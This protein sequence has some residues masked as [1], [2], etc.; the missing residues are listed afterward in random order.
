MIASKRLA[1]SALAVL[2]AGPAL[3]KNISISITPAVELRDQALVAR[4][5]V[6]NGGDEA[7][8]SVTPVLVFRGQQV[9]GEARNELGPQ[10]AM[11]SSLSVPAGELGPGRWP[12]R[13][14]VDYT[15]ANQYPFQAL[16]AGL[17]TV[18]SPPPAKLAVAEVKGDP[19]SSS[20]PLRVRMKNLAG[21]ERAATVSVAV[22][23][24]IEATSPPQQVT[25]AAWQEAKVE[26][27]L[28]NRTA[29][30]GSRY[31]VFVT[32]E[33]DDEGIHQAVV[34]QGLVEIH[35]QQSFFETWR[36]AFWVGAAVFVLAWLGFLLWR[37]MTP[38]HRRAETRP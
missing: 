18:G 10:E 12:Y 22:P 7:A 17:V 8:Q 38:R 9:R 21:V 36:T 16:H 34:A 33:Y 2:L 27:T 35:G 11:Q 15:D 13:V 29:L 32:V 4:I 14:A 20:S 31:P 26:A 24:G 25:I 19:L 5:G 23:E 30:A 28:V 37:A 1:S 6:R 3:A